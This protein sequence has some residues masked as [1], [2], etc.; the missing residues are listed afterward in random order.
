MGKEKTNA[1][2]LANMGLFGESEFANNQEAKAWTEKLWIVSFLAM[3]LIALLI[4]FL[5]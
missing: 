3:L 4:D 5:W 1:L 2:L